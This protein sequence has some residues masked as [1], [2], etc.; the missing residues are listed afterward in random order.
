MT[1]T[2]AALHG[3]AALVVKDGVALG[4]LGE[5]TRQ[6]ALGL[7]WAGLEPEAMTEAGINA[8]LKRQLAGAVRCLATDH[9]ELRRWL[10]DAGWLCRDGWGRSYQRAARSALPA[11]RQA[12]AA[13]LEQAFAGVGAAAW[14]EGLRAARAAE[15]LARRR[16]H[17]AGLPAAAAPSTAGAAP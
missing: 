11:A 14:V 5:D 10:C 7:V 1:G 4:G 2:P 6:Q 15:R 17:E 13:A 16:A 8:A 12:L 3:L 9:V